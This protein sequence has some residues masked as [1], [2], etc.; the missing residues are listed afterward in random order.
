[1][2]LLYPKTHTRLIAVNK[3][4]IQVK[5]FIADDSFWTL[6]PDVSIGVLSVQEIRETASLNEAQ[7]A[8]IKALLDAAN[9]AAKKYLTS[10]TISENRVVSVW[11]DAYRKFPTKKG[12]RCSVEALLK[13]VLHDNPVGSIAPTVDITN[14]ISLKYA[15]PIGAENVDAFDGDLHL[16]V[17]AGGEDFLAI[18]S[19]KPEPPCAG[20]VAYYDNAGV[21]CRCWN[22]RDSQRTCVRDD[23][24][25]EF[26][27]MECVEPE[28]V[29]ELRAAIDELAQLLE[30]YAGAKVFAKAILDTDHRELIIQA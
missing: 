8:E 14:A 7:S 30:A 21:V 27:V 26:I 5:K 17:M 11:R 20:E 29:G 24:T 3:E 23:T 15:L 9:Q 16:G 10:D 28:R 25:N 4:E 1:M 12:A 19:D 6:F 13:R 2:I 22:W 18:G